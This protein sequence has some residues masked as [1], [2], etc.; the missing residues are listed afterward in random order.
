MRS[1]E[2]AVARYAPLG[3]LLVKELREVAAGRA[4]WVLL[5]ILSLLVGYSFIEAAA[6]YA[7]ASRPA[8]QF[9]EVARHLSP[10]D[11]ILVPTFGALYLATT[12]LF[13]FVAIRL[14]G[15]ERQTGGHKLLLQLPY[16]TASLLGAKLAALGAAWLAMLAVP[17]SAL[18]L[19]FTL[20]GHVNGIELSNLLLGHFFYAAIVA[21]VA[22]VA[23]AI[24]ESSATAAIA[25]LAVTLGSW[26]LDFAASGD[27][28]IL[29]S[30]SGLSLTSFLRGFERGIFSASATLVAFVAVGALVAIAAVWLPTG[31]R[32]SAKLAA[33]GFIAAVA[34]VICLT[35]GNLHFYVDASEDQRNSFPPEDRAALASVDKELTIIVRLAP[36][37]PRFFDYERTLLGKLRR[38]LPK[39]T[40]VMEGGSRSGLFASTPDDYGEIT[41]RYDGREAKSRSTSEEE[42]LPLIYGLAGLKPP[43]PGG[44]EGYPGYPL[45]ADAKSAAL[46][47]YLLV[48]LLIVAGWALAR[49]GHRRF[50]RSRTHP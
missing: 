44:I 3:P 36:E 40:V 15:G 8:A 30:L 25:T 1:P 26:V 13:P 17:L 6:L 5:L 19:W 14:V 7:E 31:V 34:V 38:T 24:T 46:W 39:V 43:A 49:G 18:V 20:G 37:D 45:V 23:A 47:F 2:T 41:Y 27:G 29:A 10:L 22:F 32:A 50:T 4:F 35:A 48:P 11:G 42:V 21:G 12:F 16:S 9:P 28:G 33:T